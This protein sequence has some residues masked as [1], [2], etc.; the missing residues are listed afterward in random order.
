MVFE[1]EP[2][3]WDELQVLEAPPWMQGSGFG[4]ELALSG[5]WLRVSHPTCVIPGTTNGALVLFVRAGGVWTRRQPIQS[6]EVGDL[7]FFGEALAL[8]G[9]LLVVGARPSKAFVFRFTGELWTL[10]AELDAGQTSPDVFGAAVAFD[11]DAHLAAIGASAIRS[12]S[13]ESGRR[14]PT[15]TTRSTA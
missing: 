3:G 10:E 11:A 7:S 15:R 4:R 6:Q 14:S 8:D 9:D 5:D 12:S 1:R 2:S 13:R